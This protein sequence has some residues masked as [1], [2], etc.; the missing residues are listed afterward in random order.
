VLIEGTCTHGGGFLRRSCG[1][2]PIG[3][4]VYCGEPFCERHGELGAEFHEVCSRPTCQ[5]KY[6]DVH[7]HLAW[8][9]EHRAPN[10][11]SMCAEDLCEERMQH[12]CQRCLL[13]FCEAHLHVRQVLERRETPPRQMSLLLCTHCTARRRLWD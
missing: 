11:V 4:C 3:Q 7:E 13:R 6:R 10:S 1:A 5:A 2:T 9:E 8:I 12:A